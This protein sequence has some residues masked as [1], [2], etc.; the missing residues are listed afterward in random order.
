MKVAV[1]EQSARTVSVSGFTSV[2]G[3]I[4]FDF[5]LKRPARRVARAAELFANIRPKKKS[6][7]VHFL[8]LGVGDRQLPRCH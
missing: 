6:A 4:V 8:E 7:A 3:G 1:S 5:D 2:G